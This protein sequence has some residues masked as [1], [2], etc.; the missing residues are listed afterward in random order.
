MISPHRKLFISCVEI[1]VE[2]SLIDSYTLFRKSRST[3]SPIFRYWFSLGQIRRRATIWYF[4]SSSFFPPRALP[5]DFTNL[6][7]RFGVNPQTHRNIHIFKGDSCVPLQTLPTLLTPNRKDSNVAFEF[8]C[9]SVCGRL[10]I[11]TQVT[12]GDGTS[13]LHRCWL[14]ALR[15]VTTRRI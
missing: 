2:L 11:P 9:R 13:A 10:T 1:A 3:N 12:A 5:A 14:G 7:K 4:L 8:Q 15:H 6:R